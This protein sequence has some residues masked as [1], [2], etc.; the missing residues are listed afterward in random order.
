MN[1]PFMFV[2]SLS[3]QEALVSWLISRAVK[4]VSKE[5]T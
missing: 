5:T 4:V 1:A 3:A 2:A